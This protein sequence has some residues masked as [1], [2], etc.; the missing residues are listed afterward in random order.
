MNPQLA[1]YNSQE[2]RLQKEVV[3]ETL[4]ACSRHYGA[5][6]RAIIQT[7]SLARDEASY[8]CEPGRTVVL[9]DAEFILIFGERARLPHPRDIVAVQTEIENAL[10][11]RAIQCDIG[12]NR[13]YPS[14]LRSIRPHIFGYELMTCG[15]VVAGDT[16]ILSLIPRFSSGDIPLEDAWRLLQNRMIE[17]LEVSTDLADS[18]GVLPE[19]VYYRVVKLYMDMA[20]SLLL[21][22]GA[23]APSYRERAANLRSLA[24]RHSRGD[25]PFELEEFA[26]TVAGCTNWKLAPG[27][28]RAGEGERFW[29]RAIADARRLWRWELARLTQ[30]PEDASDEELWVRWA[31]QQ[32]WAARIRGWLYVIRSQGCLRG[33]RNWLK[34]AQLACE[35]S[36]RYWIYKAG[37]ELLFQLPPL[38][39][40][41]DF[42][43]P[44]TLDV[45]G[46]LPALH[47]RSA[48]KAKWSDLISEV[49]WNY[50]EFLVQTRS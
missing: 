27:S 13:S 39:A 21:F 37:T 46:R 1:R 16:G 49:A 4:K 25:W 23:Y 8:R 29:R 32:T 17:L 45:R 31:G 11:A 26:E 38:L 47:A 43:G 6:L 10:A 2:A 7:G 28:P 19:R 5:A 35:S 15:R 3:A 18:P 44:A 40:A 9:G 22:A 12:L 48:R 30:A 14:Y 42:H 34:W 33:W 50:H 36:P 20:T 41:S 24:V